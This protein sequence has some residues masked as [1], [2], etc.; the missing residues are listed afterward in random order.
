[1]FVE[2]HSGIAIDPREHALIDMGGRSTRNAD[3]PVTETVI[4]SFYHHY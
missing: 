2:N 1:M 3:T 4:R